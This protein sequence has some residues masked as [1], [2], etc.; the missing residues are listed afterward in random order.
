MPTKNHT[1][2]RWNPTSQQELSPIIVKTS[3]DKRTCEQRIFPNS[4]ASTITRSHAFQFQVMRL[5]ERYREHL[6]TALD[7][8]N[9][10]CNQKRHL[11]AIFQLFFLFQKPRARYLKCLLLK[12]FSLQTSRMASRAL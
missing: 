7:L 12:Y 6:T 5:F 4:L 3:I 1:H 8:K 9:G 2:S 10:I 11:V